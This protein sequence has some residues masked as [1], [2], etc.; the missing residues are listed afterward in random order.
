MMVAGSV[1]VRGGV[2]VDRLKRKCKGILFRDLKESVLMQ[3]LS[4]V[5]LL[6]SL[7]RLHRV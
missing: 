4:P 2:L 3:G 7:S 6:V 5:P 1:L